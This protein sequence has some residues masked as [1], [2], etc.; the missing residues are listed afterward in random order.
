MLNI[1]ISR[2][3]NHTRSVDFFPWC[4]CLSVKRF[5]FVICRVIMGPKKSKFNHETQEQQQKQSENDLT[6]LTYS[7]IRHIC[8]QTNLID[9]EVCRRHD[10]FLSIAKDGK[11][12]RKTFID[13]IQ[14]I[15]PNGNSFDFTNHLFDFLS[16]D[17]IFST[18]QWQD[19]SYVNSSDLDRR[20]YMDSTRFIIL[21]C[22]LKDGNV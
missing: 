17:N 14:Q 2:R 13:V 10:V 19:W 9:K 1:C 22:Q 5:I 8:Q 3:N 6:I 21:T 4:V 18:D 11:M 15:W 20:G 7:Q 16:V 12:H